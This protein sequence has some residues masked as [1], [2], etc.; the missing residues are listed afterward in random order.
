MSKICI[1][2]LFILLSLSCS[3]EDK[4]PTETL[5]DPGISAGTGLAQGAFQ[6]TTGHQVSGLVK[7]IELNGIKTI[8]LE[9]FSST[10]GP[11][12][13]VYL[14]NDRN[15]SIFINLGDLKST[16]GNQNYTV[17]GMPELSQYSYVLIWCQQFGVL[18]GSA[19]LK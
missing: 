3:K 1:C 11:D 19:Q 17:S 16:S 13:K 12:L 7:Y 18:F 9:N 4:A 8:R 5:D 14:A 2:T 10:N 6:G 15:A